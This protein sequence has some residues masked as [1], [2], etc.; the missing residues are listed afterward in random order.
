MQ[1]GLLFDE[2]RDRTEMR[3]L[4]VRRKIFL[5]CPRRLC[6]LEVGTLMRGWVSRLQLLL[7][8]ASVVILRS[9]SRGTHDHVLLSRIRDS[10]NLEGQVP[11]FISPR[12][13]VADRRE[14]IKCNTKKRVSRAADRRENTN[15]NNQKDR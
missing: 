4:S 1:R 12:N 13:R 8:L 3:T 15:C 5:F 11:L 6:V 10:S 14:N 2:M 7:A 9:E